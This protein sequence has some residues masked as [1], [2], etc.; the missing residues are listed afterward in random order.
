MSSQDLD[1][2]FIHPPINFQYLKDYKKYRRS[3]LSIPMGV[4][5]MTDLLEREGFGV[6][7][8]NYPLEYLLNPR[9]SLI[10]KL[11]S[12]NFKVVAVDLH[13]AIHG[14]G[15][16]EILRLVKKEFP[17]CF[18]VLGGLTASFYHEEIM[19]DYPQVDGVIRGDAEVPIIE[20]LKNLN[21]LENVPNLTYRQD[22]RITVNSMN[23][24]SDNLDEL[25]FSR[26]QSLEH[27]REYLYYLEKTMG[28]RWPVIIARGCMYNCLFCGGS[29]FAMKLLCNRKQVIYRSPRRVVDDL[30]EI[31][32]LGGVERIFYGHGLYP[33]VKKYFME[34]NRL[35]RE[36]GLELGADQEIWR[37]PLSKEYLRDFVKTYKK[38][39]MFIFSPKSFSEKYRKK[40]D[41]IFGKQDSSFRFTNEQ[42]WDLL[43]T[44]RKHGVPILMFWDVG[45]PHEHG[46]DI[47]R[48]AFQALRAASYRNMIIMEPICISPGSLIHMHGERLGIKHSVKSFKVYVEMMKTAKMGMNP[49]NYTFKHGNKTLSPRGIKL[50]MGVMGLITLLTF[51]IER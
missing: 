47:L 41:T 49:L 30:K 25:N 24:V 45:Y 43:K 35:I 11:K 6:K 29:H 4:F 28:F 40:F 9:F 12:L 44:L 8:L 38:K 19:K 26:I 3:F 23:Y 20:L 13:W 7:I 42:L 14:Y 32:E 21:S 5:G 48:N 31:V 1:I 51:L 36:E 2:I 50:A 33:S 10:R 16:L 22:G 27:W 18:T 46:L 37:L 15:A 39:S 34:I 17:S